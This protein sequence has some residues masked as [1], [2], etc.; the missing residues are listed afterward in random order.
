LIIILNAAISVDGKICTRKNDS[1]ISSYSDLR[2]VHNL[3]CNVDGIMV[4]ISTVLNDDPLLNT[5]FVK[6]SDE[7]KNPIRVI[8]DS[9]ARIPLDSKIVKTAKDIKTIL[10]VTK[11]AP[12]NKLDEL[13]SKNIKIIMCGDHGKK[14]DLV[15]TFE[16]LE[17][18]FGINKVL[19]EGGGEINWSI[20]KNNL[21]DVLIVTVSPIIIGGRNTITLVEGKG[22]NLIKNCPKLKLFKISKRDDGEITMYYNNVRIRPEKI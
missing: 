2:R 6:C 5:R 15:K 14:V 16:Q 19:V 4:G 22:Y 12:K 13:Q 7:R 9:K 1:K 20:I 10:S 11:S 3:R 17:S 21:F 18:K 8:I